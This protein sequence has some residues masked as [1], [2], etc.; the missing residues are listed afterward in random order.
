MLDAY[1][2]KRAM[3]GTRAFLILKITKLEKLIFVKYECQFTKI[4]F[5]KNKKTF[6]KLGQSQHTRCLCSLPKIGGVL[7]SI[8]TKS[9]TKAVCVSPMSTT[10]RNDPT[11]L[12]ATI[13]SLQVVSPV[14]IQSDA[15]AM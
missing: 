4:I 11:I 10:N 8:P 12:Q 1:Q 2:K 14:S 5:L 7:R 13:K 6:C 15:G 9:L 3:T